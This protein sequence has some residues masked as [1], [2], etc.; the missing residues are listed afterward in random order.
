MKRDLISLR[1]LSSEE[2]A[3]LLKI[4]RRL[5][6]DRTQGSIA[7]SGKNIALLFQKPSNRTR[8]SF[9]VGI[10]QLGANCIYLGP[11]EIKLGERESPTDIARTSSRYLDGIVIRANANSD[12]E[13]LAAAAG[14]PVINALDNL[15]H[16]CQGLTDIFSVKE[17]F[18]DLNG[19]TMTY[20]GDGN[21][22]CHSLIFG[23]A[24]VG[25]NLRIA[26]P[27]GYSPNEEILEAGR[28]LAEQN[29]C[30]ITVMHDP[31]EAV[32]NVQVV[33]TDVWVS[34]GQED[35]KQKRL[36]DFHGFQ[37]DQAMMNCAADDAIF[38]HCLPAYRGVEVSE[39]VID[40]PQSIVFDQAENR[41]HAQ[42]AILMFLFNATTLTSLKDLETTQ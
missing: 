37:V 18:G 21:N 9:E 23:C 11:E 42:K 6:A 7:L 16:P 19:L 30:T 22:V 31:R 2:V 35:E 41:L 4:T 3:F 40:G 32:N 26:V 14:V 38:M 27:E 28:K 36:Q 12:V 29:N 10:N 17:K 8:V 25:M 39:E 5:K 33:Y 20:V 15:Y 13:E 1:H 34:M 24:H